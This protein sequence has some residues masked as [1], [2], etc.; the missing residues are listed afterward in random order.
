MK[1]HNAKYRKKIFTTA[2]ST[3]IIETRRQWNDI[4]NVLGGKKTNF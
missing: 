2:F 1:I 3:A 4:L